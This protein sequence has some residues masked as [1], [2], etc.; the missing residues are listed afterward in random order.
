M[1]IGIEEWG[2]GRG[3]AGEGREGDMKGGRGGMRAGGSLGLT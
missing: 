3:A 1:Y 2:H